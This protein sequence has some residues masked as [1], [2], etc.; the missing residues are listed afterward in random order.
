MHATVYNFA[1][2]LM[3]VSVAGPK[4]DPSGKV[5]PDVTPAHARPWFKLNMNKLFAHKQQ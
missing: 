3:Y 4:V 5:T 1:R 2:N